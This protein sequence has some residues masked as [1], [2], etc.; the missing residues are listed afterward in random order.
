MSSVLASDDEIRDLL[1]GVRSIAVVGL[2]ERQSRPSFGVARYLMNAGYEV[3]PINPHIE[4]WQGIP[5]YPTVTAVD[6]RVDLVDVFRRPNFVLE[7]VEDAIAAESGAVWT[8]L[9][10]VSEEAT[11]RA[12]EADMP[13]VIDRCTAIEHGR[14]IGHAGRSR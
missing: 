13:M 6:R 2:S 4:S 9:G 8:Q 5:A 11:Q 3:I 1:L 10:V 14:L 7:T 12:V